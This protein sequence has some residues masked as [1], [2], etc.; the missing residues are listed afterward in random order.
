M[1]NLICI[2][3]V[4]WVLSACGGSDAPNFGPE[5]DPTPGQ[6]SAIMSTSQ[7]LA[8][9]ARADVQ[10]Q[11]AAGAA[12]SFAF[13]AQG[14]PELSSVARAMALADC[15]VVGPN[16]V[17]WHHCTD[18]NGYTI[19]GTLSWSTGHVDV[20]IRVTSTGSFAFDYSFTGSM[21][22]SATAIEGDMTVAYSITSDG[23]TYSESFRTQIDVQLIAGCISSGTLTVTATGSGP[24]ARSGAV[25]VIWT[26]CNAF[27]VRNA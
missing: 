2:T 12:I 7:D 25:Q 23:M 24:G 13:T 20:D 17:V 8:V 6:R 19:D 26:G 27:R 11:Q 1:R 5:T 15:G 10:G 4:G 14:L 9:L 21:T 3:M 22:T 18:S 16:S